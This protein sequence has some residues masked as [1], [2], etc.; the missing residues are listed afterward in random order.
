MSEAAFWGTVKDALFGWD[1]VRV[2]TSEKDGIPDVNHVHGWIELKQED[3]W[4]VRPDTPLRVPHYSQQQR[5]WHKR[6]CLAG[7]RCHVL[8]KVKNDIL[9]FWGDVAAD[10]LGH[11]P[12]AELLKHAHCH[13]TTR[14]KWKKELKNAIL[15]DRSNGGR[16]LSDEW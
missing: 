3:E 8:I 9:L 14:Q 12:R 2:E 5:V 7:G 6:R 13:W 16:R 10:H 15:E 11:L 1:P 4:P